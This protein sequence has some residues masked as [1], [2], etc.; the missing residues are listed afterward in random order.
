MKK[1]LTLFLAL[2]M[3]FSSVISVFAGVGAVEG[4]QE[5]TVF[6]KEDFSAAGLDETIAGKPENAWPNDGNIIRSYDSGA[7]MHVSPSTMATADRTIYVENGKLVL[8][9]TTTPTSD[10]NASFV[11]CMMA[12][13][14]CQTLVFEMKVAIEQSDI[15]AAQAK[16][17]F[18]LLRARISNNGTKW[19]EYLSVNA[20][21]GKI[22][23]NGEE[24]SGVV[25]WGQEYT[26]SAVFRTVTDGKALDIYLDGEK[27]AENLSVAQG[28]YFNDSMQWR[29][30]FGSAGGKMIFDSISAYSADD[31]QKEPAGFATTTIVSENFEGDQTLD[32]SLSLVANESRF[33]KENDN[34]YFRF[35]N[36]EGAEGRLLLK[37]NA[38]EGFEVSADIRFERDAETGEILYPQSV[39]TSANAAMWVFGFK[40]VINSSSK[41]GS[42][43]AVNKDGEIITGNGAYNTGVKV[44]ADEFTNI[45]LRWIETEKAYTVWVNDI[46]VAKGNFATVFT[47]TNFDLR[48]MN[49][50]TNTDKS[51]IQPVAV[52]IDNIVLK[53]VSANNTDVKTVGAQLSTDT[54]RD[55]QGKESQSVRFVAGVNSLDYK[56]IGFTVTEVNHKAYWDINGTT[57]YESILANGENGIERVNASDY[58]CTYLFAL[59]ITGIPVEDLVFRVTPYGISD[60]GTVD[61]YGATMVVTLKADRTFTVAYYNN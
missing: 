26:I 19:G 37:G 57:V 56:Q 29:F 46:P 25:T 53:S 14:S 28:E 12:A 58:G 50:L 34:T 4:L 27:I 2:V 35:V 16:P 42:F 9:D 45:R 54:I 13:G 10:T 11:T 23:S 55:E 18:Y 52:N 1:K 21:N 3:I 33:V 8:D 39:N 60:D 47:A 31:A 22:M 17:F 24:T 44:G 43:V 6:F 51:A 20:T 49:I 38:P 41:F 59:T 5:Q 32:S 61:Y 7:T 48:L 15:I 30:G 40:S 36:A